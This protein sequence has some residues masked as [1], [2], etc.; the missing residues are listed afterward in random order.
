[1]I[2]LCDVVEKGANRDTA[3]SVEGV[4]C[5]RMEDDRIACA[6]NR[7]VT[8]MLLDVSISCEG[9]RRPIRAIEAIFAAAVGCARDRVLLASK[10]ELQ[11][12]K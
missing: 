7:L 5:W 6:D 12:R 2:L 11:R 1:M 4:R 10:Q 9:L 8:D 3:A